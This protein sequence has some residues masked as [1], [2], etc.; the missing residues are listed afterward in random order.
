MLQAIRGPR[1]PGR[2]SAGHPGCKRLL[3]LVQ[4]L[5]GQVLEGEPVGQPVGDEF[6]ETRVGHPL[7][8]EGRAPRLDLGDAVRSAWRYRLE[9]AL[10]CR[11]W[12]AGDHQQHDPDEPNVKCHDATS[13]APR[14]VCLLFR[15][16]S[17]AII[18]DN[19]ALWKSQLRIANET[20]G[21]S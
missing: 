14:P 11:Q 1:R 21:R 15:A 2:C 7:P 3:G 13:S 18:F 8:A 4:N 10:C 20:A 19:E 6:E 5:V 16:C 17:W 9:L 12:K